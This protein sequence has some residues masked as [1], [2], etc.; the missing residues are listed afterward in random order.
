MS[1][2]LSFVLRKRAELDRATFQR[3]WLDRHAPLVSSL[4]GV[5]GIVR[6]QQV[7]TEHDL[8]T[9]GGEP[10]E[11]VAEL[12]L[13]PSVATGSRDEQRAGIQRLIDD[14]RTFIDLTTS[15]LILGPEVVLQDGPIDGLR[16]TAVLYRKEGTTREEFRRYWQHVH[17]PLALTR[18]DLLRA[19]RYLQVHAPDNAETWP[20][21]V[22]RGAPAPFDGL[23][24]AFYGRTAAAG[25]PEAAAFLAEIAADGERFID[26]AR[27]V[28]ALG[29]VHLIIGS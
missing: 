6:Y 20:P 25:S 1:A 24:E 14:E 17:A 19:T 7:H 2:R 28:T 4:A 23:G 3:Y 8:P 26:P 5:L 18:P 10:F 29:R 11:G 15:P 21:A 13:D 9:Y 22:Q 27:S 12:W 16:L